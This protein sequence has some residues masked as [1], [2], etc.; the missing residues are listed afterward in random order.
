M[1]QIVAAL[2]T[3]YPQGVELRSAY[4]WISR[5]HGE[6]TKKKKERRQ[7]KRISFVFNLSL[8]ANDSIAK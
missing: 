6:E 7:S 3:R 1:Q 4:N 5:E 2:I 8:Y